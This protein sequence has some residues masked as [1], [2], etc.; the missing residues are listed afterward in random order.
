GVIID[1][2]G[3]N[4]CGFALGILKKA[5]V[6]KSVSESISKADKVFAGAVT[7]TAGTVTT[8]AGHDASV[9]ETDADTGR[10]SNG[11]SND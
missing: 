9:P 5:P 3:S 2:A 6:F 10:S 4:I 11:D 1:W 7:H 8:A